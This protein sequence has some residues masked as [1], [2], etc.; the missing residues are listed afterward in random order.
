MT[1]V[2]DS[3]VKPVP[4]YDK[5]V[6]EYSPSPDGIDENLLILLHGFGT[7]SDTA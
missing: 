2:A 4:K 3:V 6:Y 5:L 1:P 7:L